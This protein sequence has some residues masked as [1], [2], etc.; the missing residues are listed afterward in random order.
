M[1]T[2]PSSLDLALQ[3]GSTPESWC[4]IGG[5]ILAGAEASKT[6]PRAGLSEKRMMGLEPTTFCMA[7]ASGDLTAPDT[8]DA[9][10]TVMRNRPGRVMCRSALSGRKC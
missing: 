10:R 4:L 8:A 2:I 6:P 3:D 5:L 9:K 1:I 7:K